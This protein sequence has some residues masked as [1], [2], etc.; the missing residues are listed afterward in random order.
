MINGGKTTKQQT[1]L[2]FKSFRNWK[3]ED[4]TSTPISKIYILKF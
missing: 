2:S 1:L 3:R 4:I